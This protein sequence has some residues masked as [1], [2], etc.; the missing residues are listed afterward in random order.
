MST[1]YRTQS[2]IDPADGPWHF[3]DLTFSAPA[4]ATWIEPDYCAF[5]DYSGGSVEE[6]NQRFLGAL[7]MEHG[8]EDDDVRILTGH[9]GHSMN[10]FSAA[11]YASDA[12][13]EVREVCDALEGYSIASD[14]ALSDVER[15]REEHAW[16][17]GV[18]ADFI[19][20]IVTS[21]KWALIEGLCDLLSVDAHGAALRELAETLI[22]E[23][24]PC[25]DHWSHNGTDAVLSERAIEAAADLVEPDDLRAV[26]A[27]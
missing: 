23:V 21:Q 5:G 24:L 27:A 26:M 4:E 13:A 15:E 17:H 22:S 6:A 16:E 2:W 8:A 9:H 25:G 12:A 19:D 3:G 11:W 1:Y 10:V 18:C 7:A 20:A 14:Q